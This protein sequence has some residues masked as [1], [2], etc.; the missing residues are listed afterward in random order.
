MSKGFIGKKY[1][2]YF[3]VPG[4][5]VFSIFLLTPMLSSFYY[6]LTDWN[7]NV[8]GISFIGLD[9]FRELFSDVK[10]VT[11]LK[12][13]LIYAISV[14]ALRNFIGLALALLLNTK[15]R[16]QN[17]FRATF[18]LPLVIA[19]IIIGYI[20]TVIYH[21]DLGILNQGFRAIGWNMLAQDW[22]HDPKY[23]LF[24][25]I[26]VDVWRTSG[27][28]MVIYLAGLQT[29]PLELLETADIDGAG[30][31]KK[32][33]HVILPLL[34]PAVTINL[35]LSLIGTMKVFEMILALTRGGP[36]YATEVVNTYILTSF[37]I[38]LFGLG[39]AA[40]LLLSFIIIIIGMPVFFFL[41]RREIEL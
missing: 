35:V 16:L 20:F 18:F 33:T 14:T 7:I 2:C 10:L 23:A 22:L 41:K 15:V 29:I 25:T 4:V 5:V 6:S 19:P 26:V 12:N 17:L 27:F 3:F 38:G 30:F 11:A 40:N 24:S 9:N 36:G 13:T 1:P 21:P 28:A 32:F 37:S 31:G 8:R 34:A 39:T